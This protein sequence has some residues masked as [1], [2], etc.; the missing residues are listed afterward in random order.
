MPI[1]TY[2]YCPVSNPES[3]PT[4]CILP[5]DKFTIPGS[6]FEAYGRHPKIPAAVH[7]LR[8]RRFQPLSKSD[9]VLRGA[10]A[11]GSAYLSILYHEQRKQNK[12]LLQSFVSPP[13]D[14]DREYEDTGFNLPTHVIALEWRRLVVA[15]EK[16]TTWQ[17]WMNAPPA[18]RQLVATGKITTVF[19]FALNFALVGRTP[20][21]IAIKVCT[22]AVRRILKLQEREDLREIVDNNDRT[23]AIWLAYL[24]TWYRDLYL[25]GVEEKQRKV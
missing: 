13:P 17:R 20:D 9:R 2:Y 23:Q 19:E 16:R 22:I 24:F 5:K 25:V 6:I 4:F 15:E 11:G 3:R 1:C 12:F 10:T 7:R 8:L 18:S 14:D 21:S